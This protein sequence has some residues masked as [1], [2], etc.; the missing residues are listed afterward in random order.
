MPAGNSVN[1]VSVTWSQGEQQTDC[2]VHHALLFG[3]AVGGP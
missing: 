1:T 2:C 3:L